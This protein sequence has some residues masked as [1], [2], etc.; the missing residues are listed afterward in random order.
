M[1]L[2]DSRASY[3]HTEPS[4]VGIATQTSTMS[5]EEVL[6]VMTPAEWGKPIEVDEKWIHFVDENVQA[7]QCTELSSATS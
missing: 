3:S 1:Q 5:S 2:F 6:H 4:S 7:S